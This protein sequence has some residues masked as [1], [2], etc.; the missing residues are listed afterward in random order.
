MDCTAAILKTC[1]RSR[2]KWR[3]HGRSS[4]CCPW[5]PAGSCSCGAGIV[6]VRV[7]R[8]TSSLLRCL[9][10]YVCCC[11]PHEESSELCHDEWADR[12]AEGV[13][14]GGRGRRE[15]EGEDEELGPPPSVDEAADALMTRLG[16]L[17]GEK[18][19]GGEPD[20]SYHAQEDGQSFQQRISPSS[21]LASSNTSPCSTLQ[22]PAGREGN[23]NNKHISTNHAS[24][25]SPTSTL[26]SRDSGIIATL[27]SYSADS[28]AERDDGAKYLGDCCHGSSFNLWQQGGRP[29]VASTSSSSMMAAAS[30][31]DGF[32]YRVEDNMAASTYSLNKLHPDR[33]AGSTRSS[34]STHSIP[35]YLMPRPNSVAATSS[36]HLEDLAY[37]D[38]QQR[39][40]PSRTSLRMPRQNSGS[41]SQQDHRVRFTPSL[42]LKPLHFEVPG[43][44]SDWLFTGREWLYQEVDGCLRSDDQAKSQGVVIVGNMGFGKTAIVARLVALSCH[45]HRMWPNAASSKT[46]PKHVE[47]VPFSHDSLGRGGGGGG[48]EEGGGG[49]GG[50]CPGTPEMRR[51]QEETLRRLAGQVVSYHFCQADNCH[52]CLVPEFVHNMVAMLS[53]APQLAA[54]REL[55]QRSPQLQSMLSLRSCI[56]DPSSA[57]QRG[58]LE[59]LDA[60]YRE[61]K[62]H[63]EG[64]GLIVLIDG[65]NEAEFHR[66]DY[67][68]TLTSF[69]S[70]NIQKFPSWLKII[71][72]VR[73]SQQDI[74]SSLPFHRISLDRMED[75]NA[76]DQDLQGYLMQRIHS[77]AEIQSNVSLSNGRLDNTALAKLVS[78]LKSLSRGSYLYLKLTLDLI[79]GG[80]LVLKSSSFKVVPV[81]LAEVYLLQLNMRF[82][83][84]SS[85]QRVLPLLNVTV[86]SLHPL[87]EQ[88][89]FEVV[90][91]GA[92]TG[93][94]LQWSEFTQRLEQ[95]SPFL[96]RRSDGSRMLKHASFREWLVWREEGQDDRFLCD[97]RSGHTLL[98]FWLCRQDGKLN[99]QQTLEL[100]HH[101][102]KAHI[103]KGLSKKLRVSS[104]VLQGLW[105]SYSTAS[106][107]PVL[108]SLRNLY[109]PNI[110]VSRLLIIGGADVDCRCDVLNNA[111]LLCVH[112]HLGHTDAVALLL[113]H[114]AQVDAQSQDGLTALGFAA[115]AGRLDIVTMLSQNKAKVGHVD[116]S[117]RCVLVHAAQRGQ[118]EV[119]RFLLRC[120]D[121]SCTSCCG[122]R[123][124][125]RSQAVQQALTA[126]ASMGHAEMV[127]YLLD[128]PEED[129]E[130]EERPEINTYDSL[131]GETALTAAAGRG[132]LPV[133]RLLLDQ[134]AAVDQGNRQGVTPLFSAVRRGHWQVVELL[135]NHGVEVNM[136]DQQ[137][138][139]ALMTAASEGHVTTAQLL[140]DHG[141]S[142]NQ[143]DKEG[144]TALSWACLK[145]QL[146]L[147]RELVERGAT[148]THADRSGRTP[149]DLAA[150]C[151]DPEVVQYLVDHGA[152]VEHVDCS[153]MRPLDRAVGCRNTSAV[154][155]LL[156]KGAQ[157]GPATWAMATSKPDILMVLL[158]KLIQEGDKLYKQGKVREAAHSYQS[159]LQK[160]PGDELKTFRQL[161]VCVLLNLSRCR[162]K[163]NDFSLAE[164]LATKALELK[165]KSYEAFYA[166]ARAKRSRRQFHAAL[167]D[168]I[169]A[170]RLCPSNREIQRLMTRVKDEC[171]QAA[172]ESPPPSHHVYQQNVAMSISEARSR[173]SGSLQVPDREGLTEEEEEEEE[174]EDETEED[175]TLR[176]SSFYPSPVI[177]SLETRPRSR[178]P[179]PSSLSPTHLYHPL[180]SPTHGAS[181]SSPSH[182]APPLPSSSY[183]NFSPTSSPMQHL[184]RAGPMSETMSALSGGSH[185][186]HAQSA[187]AFHHSDQDQGVQQLHHLTSQR[188]IQNPIQGQWLQPAK[189]QVVRTSQPSSSAHSSMVLGSSAYTQFAHLPQELAELGEG[190]GPSPLDVR[191]SP[192]VQAG[193]SS[194]A[195]YALDDVD[196]DMVCQVRS[197]SAHTRGAGG[198]RMGINRFVQSHQ[199]SRNQ[200]KAAYY[201][202]ELTEATLGPSDRL[203]PSHDYQYHHQ[204]GFRR[205]LSAH[206]TPSSAPTPRPLIHSQ[207]VNVRFSPSSGSLTSGQ[208]ANHGPGF[209]TSA[210]AQHMDLPA[211]L[212]SMGGYHDDLFLISSPQSE[213]SM[214]GGGTYP[215]EV[216]RSSR[217]TPFMGITD[218]T[219]VH[220]QYQQ[221][222]PSSSASCLSPSRSWAVSSVDTVVT[223]PSK[224]PTSQG[225][226]MPPQPSSIAYHNRSNNNAHNGHLLHDNQDFY[227]VVPNNGRQ[228]E[229]SGQ[230]VGQNPS[231][232]DVKVARTLPVIHSCSDRPTEK[233]TGPTSPVKPKRPFVESNV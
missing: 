231:Y 225:G 194:G 130:E 38:E 230:V 89:L 13:E 1:A 113:D 203:Q 36:A 215:G 54:Y 154:I 99:R 155:A 90:N 147:V 125:S 24:V 2:T 139:T 181:L 124:A 40:L 148:T 57:L 17:L 163:M 222:A 51:R 208:P 115:A 223:S 211:D 11:R 83:T 129:E 195:S 189:A 164:E 199:F 91:A 191:P 39:H 50:S 97:P 132:R 103:Y 95:L 74:T 16:F 46:L 128:L 111:P 141:A 53:D 98:A 18:V 25:T 159:A 158:S 207:S 28:A 217:N 126:A 48:G 229:G 77:S 23:N 26:E 35:L 45:G 31:N 205:P 166:R 102:L 171:R 120:A 202:M 140:L 224:N 178:G 67:G 61:R 168:L 10:L 214:A 60:L 55:L 41:R 27:T 162:R 184:Q 94:M 152:S 87:T 116:V 12:P 149:L 62:L 47:P 123:G 66:P 44:S 100:G 63:V 173:D 112:A 156:K 188:S 201:P 73:T 232:L 137:G 180:P 85:F 185:H 109:T 144:L 196:V 204:G 65:L 200:T 233:R 136:V 20:S 161:R 138:R 80:Y 71:T 58:I 37:L 226:F 210:S 72:T 75:N 176:E 69:L 5:R 68:D 14:R 82:P 107:S 197:T 216:G 93:G 127:S 228:G 34:G 21:S 88:Q 150:F 206:P 146:L 218:K 186:Q 117:G 106:L 78:H 114:G 119:L 193:L 76:I 179:S 8:H 81:S 133:C 174:E 30:A 175:G 15:E 92:L 169:E 43:L 3:R 167:E 219:R 6:A 118:L 122:Q 134:G 151:G 52:T 49:G 213:I 227:E 142:L 33:G 165:A 86:A 221:P 84:Q 160:F 108:S 220:H 190:F 32:L 101:I 22:P 177:Q 192:Q 105:L 64:A 79:E 143:T 56:Q 183:H 172:H 209:R 4:V 70:R 104:S 110:K 145:G 96:I 29:V 187:S 153:G 121:W 7:V 182:S 9:L 170:S 212:S 157:I 131:W 198:D 59:P 19:I 135:L 42:N